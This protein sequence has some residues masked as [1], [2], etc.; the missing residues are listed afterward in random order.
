MPKRNKKGPQESDNEGRPP[1]LTL[2]S[3]LTAS[4]ASS[5]S[6]VSQSSVVDESP[7]SSSPIDLTDRTEPK[8]TGSGLK[9]EETSKETVG[10]SV[11][12][13][14]KGK[15]PISYENRAKGKKVTVIS[16]VTG[17]PAILLHELKKKIGAGGVVRGETV[18][19]QGDHQIV[20][21]KFLTGRSCLK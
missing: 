1:E 9:Q 17:D 6:S 12:R 11:K 4:F 8:A 16:N 5:S 7:A 18:E 19:I 2:A 10:F 13:T 3:F 15:L 21:E 20:V 14:K